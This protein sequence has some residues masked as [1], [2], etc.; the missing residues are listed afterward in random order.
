M[1]GVP[2]AGTGWD[3][4]AKPLIRKV[5]MLQGSGPIVDSH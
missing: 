4:G 1:A 3:P 5:C 2:L